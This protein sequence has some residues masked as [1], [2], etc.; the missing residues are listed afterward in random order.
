M[1]KLGRSVLLALAFP[2]SVRAQENAEFAIASGI[3][4]DSIRGGYL[5]NALVS[6]SGT[7][8]HVLTDTLGRFQID[9]LI[10]GDYSFRLSHPLLDTLGVGV[11][12]QPTHIMAGQKVQL[13]LSI[14]SASTVVQRKCSEKARKQ[15]DAAL[16]GIVT[17]ADTDI[18]PPSAEVAVTWTDFSVG[19]KTVVKSVQHRAAKTRA[20]GSYVVCGIPQ[21]LETGV[22]A[23]AGTDST[24]EIPV[25]F[26]NGLVLQS[27]HLQPGVTSQSDSNAPYRNRATVAGKVSDEKGVP[28]EGARVAVDADNAVTTT[29]HDG[30]FRLAGVRPGTRAISVRKLGHAARDAIVDVTSLRSAD[31]TIQLSTATRVL[32]TVSISALRDVGLQRVGFTERKRTAT[33]VFFGQREIEGK[34]SPRLNRIIETIPFFRDGRYTC[35]RYWVDGHMW[36]TA[37]DMDASE[38]PD[39]FLSGAEIGAV[40]VY[41]PLYAP[42]EFTVSSKYGQCASVVIWTKSKLGI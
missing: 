6:V 34:N 32:P 12:T 14:P 31:V 36:S 26:T 8:R 28:I 41:T 33:G 1:H 23:Y 17:Y 10:E 42:A 30:N 22:V 3:A 35:M 40:E 27:F 29:D 5:S 4:L 37:S 15:G 39:A 19:G 21:D 18:P 25:S 9:S 24:S 20:D 38:G 13:I 16:I 11:V 7:K 2:A